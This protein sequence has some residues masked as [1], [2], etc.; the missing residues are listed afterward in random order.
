MNNI[1]R[2]INGDNNQEQRQGWLCP[3]C[4]ASI[5]PD[6]EVCPKCVEDIREVTDGGG[7][8]ILIG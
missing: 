7:K 8:Q 3:K 1:L 4:K 6:K 2:E 5:S